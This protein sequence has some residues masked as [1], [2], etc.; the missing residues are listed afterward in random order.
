MLKKRGKKR[1]IET[2]VSL[3]MCVVG[4]MPLKKVFCQFTL[5]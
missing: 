4:L 1:N 5:N 2:E 3:R